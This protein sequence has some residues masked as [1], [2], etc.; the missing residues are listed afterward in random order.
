MASSKA[1]IRVSSVFERVDVLPIFSQRS[2]Q[3]SPFAAAAALAASF[4][5][6]KSRPQGC[7][8]SSSPLSAAVQMAHAIINR[9]TTQTP[10]TMP[11]TELPATMP[12]I[13]LPS[14]D[15]VI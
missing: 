10:A 3:L 11:F 12:L 7:Y 6:Q 15:K 4:S 1:S 2:S 13:E 5:P 9:L 14:D 8:L